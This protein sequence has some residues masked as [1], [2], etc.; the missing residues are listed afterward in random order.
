MRNLIK[1]FLA[2]LLLVSVNALAQ[3]KKDY[4]NDPGYADFGN[5]TKFEKG[6]N[7]TEVYIEKN[8]LGMV[9]K[10]SD[11][12]DPELASLLGGLKLVRVNSFHV[13]DND[14]KSITLRI[15]EVDKNLTSKNW[16]RIV[17]VR[18]NGAVTNVYI[19]SGSDSNIDGLVVTTFE[20][21]GEAAFI[22][23]V[24]KINLETIGKLSDKF[25]I[26]ELKKIKDK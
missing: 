6:D 13:S 16:S 9:A 12:K 17:K 2:V 22:N 23:I 7:V 18:E 3:D 20:K 10:M 24:G 25:D 1:I 5:L 15:D 14:A 21:D 19:K 4:S 26:P 11:K 8:L